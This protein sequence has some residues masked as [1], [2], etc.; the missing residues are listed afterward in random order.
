[1]DAR[2]PV[3]VG[4]DLR[5][6]PLVLGDDT[7]HFNADPGGDFFSTVAQI[8]TQGKGS[9]DYGFIE[10]LRK[11]LASQIVVPTEKKAFMAAK[12]GLPALNALSKTYAR[13]VMSDPT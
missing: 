12:I 9:G 6:I 7:Y 13:T 3:Q 4:I 1:M 10:E 2:E 11:V 8:D 5:P